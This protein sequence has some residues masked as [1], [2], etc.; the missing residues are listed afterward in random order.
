MKLAEPGGEQA[1]AL[2]HIAPKNNLQLEVLAREVE[3]LKRLR[4]NDLAVKMQ[5]GADRRC[6]GV[7]GT[8]SNTREAPSGSLERNGSMHLESRG[9]TQWTWGAPPERVARPWRRSALRRRS[10]TV[11]WRRSDTDG[12]ILKAPLDVPVQA[13]LPEE[14]QWALELCF[15]LGW[16]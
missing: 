3:L 14:A 8:A 16:R 4:G 11:R 2:K 6:V 15:E 10:W 1:F 12:L 7:G 5:E 13:T 9:S